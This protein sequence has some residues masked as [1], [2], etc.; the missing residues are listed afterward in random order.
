MDPNDWTLTGNAG[1]QP[2]TNFLGTTDAQPLIIKTN[3]VEAVRVTA[4]GKVGIGD[5][6]PEFQLQVTAPNQSGIVVLAPFRS[7]GAGIQLQTV[8][9]DPLDQGRG[10]EL[11]ATGTDASQGLN[12]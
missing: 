11:L 10:W 8:A 5:S 12:K 4:N 6:N 1:T 7:V 2:D 9:N 3:D